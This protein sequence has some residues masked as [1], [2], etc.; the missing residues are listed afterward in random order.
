[1]SGFLGR[2]E[3]L[4]VAAS[5]AATVTPERIALDRV[6]DVFW[7]AAGAALG[8]LA[9]HDETG[10][11]AVLDRAV[12][13]GDHLLGARRADPQTG[14]RAW[15]C[16]EPALCTG[17]A[18]GSSGIAHALLRLSQ[19]TGEARFY[20]AAIEAFAWERTVYREDIGD[21]P[22]MRDQPAGRP[23]LSSWC[24][25]A[26][27]ISLS[28]LTGLFVLRPADEVD[29]VEDLDRA[30]TRTSETPVRPTD[31]LCCGN[32]GRVD[33]LL[34]AGRV[35]ENDSLVRQARSLA[36]AALRLAGQRG[37][38]LPPSPEEDEQ[39]MRAGMWQGLA[40]IGYALLRL[41]DADRYPSPLTWS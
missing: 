31:N 38:L 25:G 35:L 17:F 7:G 18:H 15:S 5:A 27:G 2:P 16:Q 4:R 3:L 8:L 12:A 20:D 33:I 23:L 41:A 11:D 19:R 26:P 13:C 30:L 9:L 22:D 32:F 6:H 40:G 1:M 14:L 37:W 10:D 29:V 21:W 36:E 39:H 28:R 24:H 34:E